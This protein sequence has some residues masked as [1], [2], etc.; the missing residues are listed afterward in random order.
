MG[1]QRTGV[2]NTEKD[3]LQTERDELKTEIMTLKNKL[4]SMAVEDKI[5]KRM[6]RS[7][8]RLRIINPWR[9]KRVRTLP[10]PAIVQS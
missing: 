9:W 10:R 7:N 2:E 5:L 4:Q 3:Q 6:I 8:R 1:N